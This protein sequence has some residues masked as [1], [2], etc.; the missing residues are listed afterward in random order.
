[1]FHPFELGFQDHCF[2]VSDLCLI[3]DLKIC[4]HILPFDAQGRVQA[5]HMKVLQQFDVTSI[6][7]LG[8]TSIKKAG[9]D[10]CLVDLQLGGPLDVVLIQHT[11]SQS[12]QG[13]NCLANP[14]DLFFEGVIIGNDTFQVLELLQPPVEMDIWMAICCVV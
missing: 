3:Q 7:G 12:A 2:N 4:N 10:N 8:L 14:G 6:Q 9:E 11:C 13:L 1:M 5:S